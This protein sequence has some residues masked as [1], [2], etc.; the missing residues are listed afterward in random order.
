MPQAPSKHVA[1][2]GLLHPAAVTAV[3]VMAL[4]DHW[5]KAT[6]ASWWTGKLSDVAGLIFFP[7]FLQAVVEVGQR[8][9]GASVQPSRR[10]LLLAIIAT[11]I[12]FGLGKST[13]PGA[14]C[15]RWLLGTLR[16]LIFAP[17]NALKGAPWTW[18]VPV[19]F[20]K[21][22][23]DLIALPSLLL[24]WRIGRHHCRAYLRSDLLASQ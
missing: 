13:E 19:R 8:L 17:L 24:S 21:D 2:E 4:N 9:G 20:V 16:W 1:G 7:L 6:Y 22:P 10:T 12:V 5:L 14:L 15:C 3:L 18:L 23:T 11:G